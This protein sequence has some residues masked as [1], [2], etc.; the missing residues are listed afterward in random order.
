MTMTA[1]RLVSTGTWWQLPHK[2]S[3][4]AF[5]ARAGELGDLPSLSTS[6]IYDNGCK[7]HGTERMA[8]LCEKERQ[9][10]DNLWL[11]ALSG[12]YLA[13]NTLS[14]CW[15]QRSWAFTLPNISPSSARPHHPKE[16]QTLLFI[17]IFCYNGNQHYILNSKLRNPKQNFKYKK[18]FH[19]ESSCINSVD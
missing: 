13:E 18:V 1:N 16:E 15:K 19:Q 10:P 9:N 12:S 11:P 7:L 2:Y 3:T 5:C 8:L 6:N 14:S 4:G 17:L